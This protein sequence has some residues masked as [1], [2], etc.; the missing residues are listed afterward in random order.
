MLI[1]GIV[2]FGI[3]SHPH[4]ELGVGVIS[5]AAAAAPS[6]ADVGLAALA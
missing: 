1:L 4:G 6:V 5:S 3:C 2:T